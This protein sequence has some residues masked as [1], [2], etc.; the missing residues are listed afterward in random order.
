M[1][2]LRLRNYSDF[3]AFLKAC[4]E[5]EFK[6]ESKQE[7]YSVIETTLFEAKY[8]S[9]PKKDKTIIRTCLSILTCY[10]RAQLSRLIKKARAGTLTVRRYQ[11][12]SFKRI[13]TDQDIRLLATTD[14]LHSIL[15]GKATKEIV[16][17]EYEVFGNKA[18]ERLSAVSPAHIYNLRKKDIY[19][20]HMRGLKF[21]KTTASKVPIG[22]R[23]K[24]TPDGRPG[25]LRV[26][27]VHQGDQDGRKGMYTIN[28]IDEVTQYEIVGAVEKIADKFLV[29][30]LRDII[31]S[32]PFV[33]AG[34]HADNGSEY[35]N[36]QVAQML[37][38]L[39]I[40][41]TKSRPRKT[42]D[43]ALVEGKN[44]S[45]VRKHMGY[46]HI[47]ADFA[48]QVHEFYT[49]F[50]NPYLNFHRPCGF[51]EVVVSADGRSKKRYTQY[52]TP[53]EKLKSLEN[54]TT[55]LKK[56]V[57]FATLDTVAYAMSDNEAARRMQAAKTTLFETIFRKENFQ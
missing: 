15:N 12:H 55:Y 23:A 43:N 18:Y 21:T 2:S 27:T 42:N 36:Y 54:A 51:A 48:P 8:W 57:T 49:N 9:L 29:P 32:Y 44:G 25:Y 34:F 47:P 45:I 17:R 13:Y 56:G 6:P 46:I 4:G 19:G 11:R 39:L 38:R 40:K 37:N 24:P 20:A 50:L 35:I 22:Q 53:Y 3:E 5:V 41:L 16:K 26:D 14:E 7:A 1:K 33:I 30:L 28:S 10:S 52:M 31:D